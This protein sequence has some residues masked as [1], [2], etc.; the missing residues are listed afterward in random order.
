M[1]T[2]EQ[3]RL[4]QVHLDFHTAGMV[5][6][7]GLDFDPEEFAQ[8]L[9]DAGVDSITCFARCHHGYLY[10]PS[11][12][13]PERIHPNLKRPNLLGEQI[14]AC[15]KR[16]IR[17]PIYITV[18]WDQ[19]LA[20]QHP[21]WRVIEESGKPEG[22]P[23]YHAGFYRRFCLNTPYVDFLKAHVKEVIEMLPTDGIFWDIVAPM[24]C[25][26]PK[27][28]ADMIAKGMNPSIKEDRVNYGK[29]VE[30][31]FMRDMTAYIRTLSKD[32]T[33]FYNAGH[34]GP[35][36]R[37]LQDA[38]THFELES[39]PSGGWGYMHF[40]LT[41]RYARTLD[42][43]FLGMTGKFHTSWGDFHSYKN[44]AALEYECFQAVALGGGCSIGDQL[45]P[46]GKI[47]KTTYEL[48]GSVYNQIKAIEPWCTQAKPV[49]QIGVITPEAFTLASGHGSLPKSS[50]GAVRILQELDHQYDI[51]DLQAD[52][53]DYELIIVPDEI[54][55]TDE[56]RD[57]LE[58]YVA[59]GGKLIALD[60]AGDNLPCLGIKHE[61]QSA[62]CPNFLH[63]REGFA[64]L[65]DADHVVY[66]QGSQVSACDGTTVLADTIGSTFNRTWEHYCSHRH[67]PSTGEVLGPAVTIKDNCIYLS[68]PHLTQYQ[69]NAPRWCKQ[70]VGAAI[71]ELLTKPMLK[72]NAPSHLFT[73]VND[74]A[75]Q[76]RY[77]MHLLN[78]VPQLKSEQIEIVEDIIPLHDVSVTLNLPKPITKATLVPEGVEVPVTDTEEGQVIQ[79][80]KLNNK[81]V[82]EL[83]Y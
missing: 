43:P 72:T 14:E 8:T 1:S 60:K 57:R 19:M 22:T 63:V 29:E 40:P 71:D 25:S 81:Q 30:A 28:K 39:L 49:T 11:K 2:I 53:A 79:L 75:D 3:L 15:H 7:I 56:L 82:I 74:Q 6:N 21:E 41:A 78:Y 16:N 54:S 69:L 34:I 65:P 38:Y 26:C 64:G 33:V 32:C 62:Y 4:R 9:E 70:V 13:M 47:C 55:V 68:Q 50:Q 80:A 46:N 67:S 66:E 10:Y 18:Q 37:D 20:E 36:H 61:G 42:L 27:C 52:F 59:D 23:P 58:S 12:L 5:E 73:A 45:P 48:I 76:S 51:I 83:S 77:V 24:D 35:R 17:V 31:K 44:Q